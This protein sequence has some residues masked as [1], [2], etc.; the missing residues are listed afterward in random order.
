[1]AASSVSAPVTPASPQTAAGETAVVLTRPEVDEAVLEGPGDAVETDEVAVGG[2]ALARA[3]KPAVRVDQPGPGAGAAAV[4]AEVG[5]WGRRMGAVWC[6][7][8][9]K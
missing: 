6:H 3:E 7:A 5:G 1:M 4:D 9:K 2:A 8:W